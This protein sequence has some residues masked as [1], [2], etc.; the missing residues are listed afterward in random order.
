MEFNSDV[1]NYYYTLT[2]HYFAMQ[3]CIST[4]LNDTVQD[5]LEELNLTMFMDELERTDLEP[6]LS[7]PD[8]ELTVF[9]PSDA[10]FN[11]LTNFMRLELLS[12]DTVNTTLAAHIA[13]SPYSGGCLSYVAR[14][15]P[16]AEDR[17]LHITRI[18]EVYTYIL[19][20]L[21]IIPVYIIMSI[22]I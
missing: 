8:V 21:Y 16:L 22:N 6:I 12:D 11:N 1:H 9:A 5:C 14:I 18:S 17:R 4:V 20:K 10:A 3:L 13:G 2:S 19:Y 15:K 7:S